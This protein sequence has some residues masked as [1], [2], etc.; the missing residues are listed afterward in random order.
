MVSANR[1]L[2]TDANESEQSWSWSSSYSPSSRIVSVSAQRYGWSHPRWPWWS[3]S[4]RLPRRSRSWILRIRI[5][6]PNGL[7]VWSQLP[8][9][10]KPTRRASNGRSFPPPLPRT[11]H[12]LPQLSPSSESKPGYRKRQPGH[13]ADEPCAYAASANGQ[14]TLRWLQPAYGTSKCEKPQFFLFFQLQ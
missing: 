2:A 12:G 3:S 13:A 4:R 1:K 14:P 7:L 5:S 6:E 9:D 10:T 11:P 8:R